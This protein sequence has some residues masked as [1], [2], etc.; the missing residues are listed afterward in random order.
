[1]AALVR[2]ACVLALKETLRIDPMIEP[3]SMAVNPPVRRGEG[4]MINNL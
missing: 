1:M 4:I 2:E 3:A